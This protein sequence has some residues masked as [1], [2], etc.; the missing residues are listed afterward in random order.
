ML[1]LAVACLS[2]CGVVP[3][4]GGCGAEGPGGVPFPDP[5]LDGG[6]A[7]D[8]LG[9]W[10]LGPWRFDTGYRSLDQGVLPTDQ[11]PSGDG[12]PPDNPADD[13]TKPAVACPACASDETCTEAKG[14]TCVE[15]VALKGP[16]SDKQVLKEVALAYIECW[17]KQPS[18]DRLC[19]AFE[20]CEMIGTLTAAMVEDWVCN[21]SQVSDFPNA[22]KH[23]K[24]QDLCGCHWYGYDRADWQIS[25]VA[26]GEEGLSCLSYDVDAW[27]YYDHLHVNR[28]KL[29]PPK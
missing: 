3:V 6:V 19:V 26:S 21:L 25:S 20:T 10:D 27:L 13:C 22:T 16:A 4:A 14:G 28:C 2:L 15:V 29:Y 9:W 1:W 11:G 17:G 18:S 23:E 5:G 24:A 7:W 12:E 8:G